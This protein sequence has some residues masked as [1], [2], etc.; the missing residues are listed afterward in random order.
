AV[1]LSVRRPP[2]ARHGVAAVAPRPRLHLRM[3]FGNT[4][5]P[6]DLRDLAGAR[7]RVGDQYL[8]LSRSGR[9]ARRS[10]RDLGPRG[11]AAAASLRG[12]LRHRRIVSLVRPVLDSLRFSSAQLGLGEGGRAA[13]RRAAY[14]RPLPARG[15][16]RVSRHPPATLAPDTNPPAAP[17]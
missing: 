16:P 13:R 8:E 5:H 15:A 1:E 2:R 7:R 12:R 14:L 3:A 6:R 9:G 17:P 4:R 10:R 11:A